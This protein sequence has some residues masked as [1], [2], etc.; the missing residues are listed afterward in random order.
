MKSS[1]S[2]A[3]DTE[4]I[5]NSPARST[6]SSNNRSFI[7]LSLDGQRLT[8]TKAGTPKGKKKNKDKDKKDQKEDR[9]CKSLNFTFENSKVNDHCKDNEAPSN[10][11]TG[12]VLDK[13]DNQHDDESG[14]TEVI[15]KD[16]NNTCVNNNEM[17]LPL[18]FLTPIN[19]KRGPK[20][21]EFENSFDVTFNSA[22]KTLSSTTM[23]T[24]GFSTANT[25]EPLQMDAGDENKQEE[26]A[27]KAQD[28]IKRMD[29]QKKATEAAATMMTTLNEARMAQTMTCNDVITMFNDL[30]LTMQNVQADIKTLQEDRHKL[31][32]ELE[33]F[34]AEQV[35]QIRDLE[36]EDARLSTEVTAIKQ[37]TES[38][39]VTI[40]TL[41][42]VN[43]EHE[44]KM[45][46]MEAK[47]SNME[48]RLSGLGRA[49]SYNKQ[50][51]DECRD[52]IEQS[53]FN[54]MRCNL[55]FQGIEK[56][57]EETWKEATSNFLK[58]TMGIAE[59]VELSKVT[60]S[61][62]SDKITVTLKNAEDKK[63]IFEC[64]KNL[65]GK[66]NSKKEFFFVENQMTARNKEKRRRNKEITKLNQKLSVA[67]QLLLSLEKGEIYEGE[68]QEKKE[69]KHNIH[70]P[71]HGEVMSL[72]LE[73]QMLIQKHEIVRGKE[74][75]V[76]DSTF[77]GHV[78]DVQTFEEV[79]EAYAL[80]RLR[81]LDVRHIVCA[82][83]LNE[84]MEMLNDDFADDEEY[85]VG[86]I[87]LEYMQDV[88]IQNRAIFITR[89][90]GGK[91]IGNKRVSAY[92]EAT[93]HAML[94]KPL[95]TIT[96][97]YQFTWPTEKNG[98]KRL[99][100]KK[101]RRERYQKVDKVF[102]YGDDDDSQIDTE[103]EED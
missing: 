31:N 55:I 102:Q 32:T 15:F 24:I 30:K 43:K 88:N 37:D 7:Q 11:D 48:S 20:T 81:N 35:K 77:Q 4:K 60:K 9:V 68:G 82:A 71:T 97:S 58:D 96:K 95:N 19:D 34:K 40:A 94:A 10:R 44:R 3:S 27:S 6:R 18:G 41:Q 46:G 93:K 47:I 42:E 14:D 62:Y 65:K 63:K 54:R 79:N 2:G 75:I 39:K 98:G 5:G 49:I 103:E 61:K 67:Q 53:D 56:K 83:R 86:R 85:S 91:K 38:S 59:K 66:T 87:I 78:V 36:S 22:E 99:K 50:L 21:V 76:E 90:S 29:A 33:S 13:H 69:Y 64:V 17:Q 73:Q 28:G 23:T 8:D 84:Q 89:R 57:K 26:D 74:V 70:T 101:G 12:L 72:T 52:K 1:V 51:I 16:K 45:A 80:V 100:L 25:E 92:L